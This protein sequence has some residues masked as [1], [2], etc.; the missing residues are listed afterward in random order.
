MHNKT[1]GLDQSDEVIF[2]Y[3]VSDEVLEAAADSSQEKAAAYTISFCSGL[4]DCPA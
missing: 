4:S 1:V 2:S 3:D